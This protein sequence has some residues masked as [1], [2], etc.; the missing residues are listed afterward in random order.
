MD[1][2]QYINNVEEENKE[3]RRNKEGKWMNRQI[4]S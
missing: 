1:L 4:K 3:M 2:Y